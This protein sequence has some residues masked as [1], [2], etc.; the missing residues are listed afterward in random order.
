LD[1]LTNQLGGDKAGA[2]KSLIGGEN[3]ADALKGLLNGKSKN[4]EKSAEGD[5]AK[6]DAGSNNEE[7]KPADNAKQKALKKLLN[8]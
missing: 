5:A 6:S 8:F 4:S 3:K 7:A 1:A 2:V